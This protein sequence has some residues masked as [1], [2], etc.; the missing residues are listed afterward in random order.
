VIWNSGFGVAKIAVAG[1]R[2]IA[3]QRLDS[4]MDVIFSVAGSPSKQELYPK[5]INLMK[6]NFPNE[7]VYPGS[8]YNIVHLDF[9]SGGK[10]ELVLLTESEF[11]KEHT[12]DVNYRRK[13]L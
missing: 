13:H 12:E 6:S 1:S 9:N 8:S 2:A 3:K 7:N 5:L 11:N 10:F 4:D